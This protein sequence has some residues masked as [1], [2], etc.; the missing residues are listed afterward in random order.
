MRGCFYIG[1]VAL[2]LGICLPSPAAGAECAECH[3]KQAKGYALTGMGRSFFRLRPE[4]VVEDFARRNLFYHE[5]SDRYYHL[6]ERNGRY[7]VRRFQEDFEGRETNVVE[8]EIHYVLG[9][10][11]HARSYLHRTPE[12]RFLQLPV[13]WYSSGGGGYWEMAPGYDIPNHVDFR[14]EITHECMSC[15]NAYPKLA[16]G[17]DLAHSEPLFPADLPEGIDCQRCHGPGAQHASAAKRGAALEAVRQAIVNPARLS[18]ERQMEVCLQCHLETTSAPLPHSLLRYGRGTYSYRPGEPI[19]DYMLHFDHAPGSGYDEKFEV[20]NAVYRL[21]KSP[22][23][24]KSDGRLTCTTCHDVHNIPRGE[25]AVRHYSA[26]C[27]SC[28]GSARKESHTGFTECLSCHMPKRHTDDAPR[29]TMTDHLIRRR[30]GATGQPKGPYRGDVVLYYPPELSRTPEGELYLAV[31]QVKDGSNLAAG[32]P[33]L[34][35]AIRKHR[36]ARGEFYY[37]LAEAHRKADNQSK[38]IALYH[39]ALDRTPELLPARRHLAIE[40]AK[41]GALPPAEMASDPVV[42]SAAGEARF[43]GGRLEEAAAALRKAISA[44]GDLPEAH[45]NLGA[46]LS[47]QWDTAGAEAAFREAIRLQPDFAMAHRNLAHLLATSGE[48]RKARYHFE[49]AVHLEPTLAVAH[50]D[51][52]TLL[53]QQGDREGALRHYR[54]AVEIDPDSALA[55]YNLGVT[56]FEARQYA[57]AR[58]HLNPAARSPDPALR[59][60]AQDLLARIGNLYLT[61]PAGPA[62]RLSKQP[63][64]E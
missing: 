1:G 52:A 8:K 21:R 32:I 26:V 6:S 50:N 34:E 46:V 64:P 3:P 20:V 40:L 30:P 14:R 22:C 39:Q 16:P 23:F 47:R 44:R 53:V 42:L 54:R 38:A 41:T 29:I 51:L 62:E 61:S 43:R 15:H 2:W 56:L 63:E 27:Q 10:G 5:A 24:E 58:E 13:T 49:K 7:Y 33:R 35:R 9:S 57:E 45:N 4:N 17:V 18:V 36:P 25:E 28:H 37:E 19:Q 55:R 11:N 12:G 60:A 59:K 48:L 31:A